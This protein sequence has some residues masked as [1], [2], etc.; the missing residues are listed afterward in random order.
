VR[1]HL[2]RNRASKCETFVLLSEDIVAA[3]LLYTTCPSLRRCHFMIISSVF[4]G[5][6]EVLYKIPYCTLSSYYNSTGEQVLTE[7]QLK[8]K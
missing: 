6:G 7:S 5:L 2:E 4:R 8:T 3:L 1:T